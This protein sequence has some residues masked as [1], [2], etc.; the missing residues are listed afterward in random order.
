MRKN[1][2]RTAWRREILFLHSETVFSFLREGIA[3]F[4]QDDPQHAVII[5]YPSPHN[6]PVELLG[7]NEK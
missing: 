7:K 6:K 4:I 3:D 5:F 1:K 2:T